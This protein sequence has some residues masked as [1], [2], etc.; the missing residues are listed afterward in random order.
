MII[1]IIQHPEVQLYIYKKI[2]YRTHLYWKWFYNQ[3]THIGFIALACTYL[4]SNTLET[5]RENQNIFSTVIL[6]AY[7]GR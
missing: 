4:F 3:M 1:N 5:T 6:Y 7:R 2:L